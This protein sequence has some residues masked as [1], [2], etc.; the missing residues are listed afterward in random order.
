MDNATIHSAA[1][2]KAKIRELRLRALTN[3]PYTP[4]LNPAEGFISLHKGLLKAEMSLFK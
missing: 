1:A 2:T 4:E 3:C